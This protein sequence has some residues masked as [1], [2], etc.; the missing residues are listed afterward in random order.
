VLRSDVSNGVRLRAVLLVAATGG[1]AA[2]LVRAGNPGNMGL[3]GACFL[4]D[5]GGALGFTAAS[6]GPAIFRPEIAGLVLGATLLALA[7]RRFV[8]R[9]GSYAAGRF[10][11]GFAMAVAAL[12][13]LGCPFRLLQRL[14]GG[15]LSAWFALP[16]FL[17]GVRFAMRFEARG[18][19]IGSTSPA[20]AAVGLAGPLAFAA[21]V[22]LFLSGKL[23]G[24]GPGASAGPPHAEARLALGIGLA[25]GGILSATGFCAIAA[26][27]GIF[28]GRRAMSAAALAFIGT[29]AA[30]L[31][32]TGGVIGA[33]P[34][35]VSHGGHAAS[36]LATFVLGCAGALAGGCP[37]RQLVMTGEGNGDAL[38][39]TAGLVVGGAVA[40]N[41]GLVS[42]AAGA[43]GP[44]GPTDAGMIVLGVLLLA[45]VLFAAA[46]TAA[47]ARAASAGETTP[48][49]T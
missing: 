40:H 49:R 47:R 16:G 17:L 21:L 41:F 42:A 19:A 26:V 31:W 3:C 46:V 2:W 23:Y 30:T 34:A 4:R 25:S 28:G 43:A 11:L 18:Y 5:L 45:I 9:S 14:G 29:Y 44:G 12:V 24:P 7:R 10:A 22:G 39:T 27:R 35:P 15:D 1:L 32:I 33:S 38:V 20:P 37:V 48:P 8:A 6:K 13:F 36:F